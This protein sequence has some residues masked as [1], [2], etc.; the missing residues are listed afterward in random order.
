MKLAAMITWL[1]SRLNKRDFA[2][3]RCCLRQSRILECLHS[4]W[5]SGEARTWLSDLFNTR[6]LSHRH[7]WFKT[8]ESHNK[9]PPW[10]GGVSWEKFEGCPYEISPV[11]EVV[12]QP[13]QG[14]HGVTSRHPAPLNLRFSQWHLPQALAS[15]APRTG[16]VVH[17]VFC[18]GVSLMVVLECWCQLQIG[19]SQPASPGHWP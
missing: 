13:G 12:L 4:W 9:L 10:K 2:K 5:H 16:A 15:A 3:W 8:K 1:L 11:R 19:F 14:L 6:T 7:A 17:D 18:V